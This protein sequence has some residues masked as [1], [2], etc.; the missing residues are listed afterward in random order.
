[1][2]D[3]TPIHMCANCGTTYTDT[4]LPVPFEEIPDL[5][6]RLDPGGEV[7]TGACACGALTYQVS[8]RRCEPSDYHSR[9]AGTMVLLHVPNFAEPEGPGIDHGLSV[10]T[11]QRLAAELTAAVADLAGVSPDDD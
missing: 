9:Q 1:M 10:N 6:N 3:Q 8:V 11:A 4:T 5:I 2:S 7:P